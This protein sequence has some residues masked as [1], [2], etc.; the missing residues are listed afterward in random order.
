MNQLV[1]C[2]LTLFLVLDNDDDAFSLYYDNTI[3]GC[4]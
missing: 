1:L 4:F 2:F 3:I